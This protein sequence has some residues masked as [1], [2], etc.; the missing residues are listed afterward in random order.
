MTQNWGPPNYPPRPPP[1]Q[2]PPQYQPP[3]QYQLPDPDYREP[4]GDPTAKRVMFFLAGGCFT[5]VLVTCCLLLLAMA[6]VV[7]ERMGITTPAEETAASVYELPQSSPADPFAPG[8]EI[9][10]PAAPPAESQPVEQPAES[11]APAGGYTFGQP[12]TAA[13]VSVELT[14]FDLQRNVQP[15]NLMPADGMEFVAVAVQL[16]S[17]EPTAFAK[18]YELSNFQLQNAQG[19]IYQPDPQA[20]DGRRL[21][22]GQLADGAIV[23]GD[24][25]FH[26]P[27]GDG[28]FT[29]L[30]QSTG[31]AQSY[32]VSL[33]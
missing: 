14:V 25:L 8:A 4:Q 7:D 18:V 17:L 5:L 12:V 13:D 1:Y 27:A 23:E 28:P 19:T 20:D 29:L 6:W 32:P 9:A 26:V 2:Q 33:Q 22:N 30:W 16:R 3:V 24:L 10:P 31:S 11:A 15:V 21:Q